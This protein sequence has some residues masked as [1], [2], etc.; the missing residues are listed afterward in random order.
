MNKLFWF[1]T[2]I[3]AGADMTLTPDPS[4]DGSIIYPPI[5]SA[6]DVHSTGRVGVSFTIPANVP[7]SRGA[8]LLTPGY[9]PETMRG[10]LMVGDMDSL[11]LVDDVH[12]VKKGG[13]LPRLVA[14]GKFLAQD[15]P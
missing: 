7:T 10:I 12:Y 9:V 2:P 1:P 8:A 4:D 11:L 5:P 13:N 14:N 6:P 15:V 3:E